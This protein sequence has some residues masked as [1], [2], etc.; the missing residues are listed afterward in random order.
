MNHAAPKKKKPTKK[1]KKRSV[2]GVLGEISQGVL[3]VEGV[4]SAV[5]CPEVRQQNGTHPERL[6]VESVES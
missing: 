1:K 4:S 5:P 2:S 6:L 3:R